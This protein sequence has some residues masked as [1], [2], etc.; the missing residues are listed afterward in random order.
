MKNKITSL[1]LV[2]ECFGWWPNILF[3]LVTIIFGPSIC[4]SAEI[5]Y[6]AGGIIE[7]LWLFLGGG[8]PVIQDKLKQKAQKEV[9][10]EWNRKKN[11]IIGKLSA[12]SRNRFCKFE[13]TGRNIS[14]IINQSR[15]D[16][17]NA[18]P[19]KLKTV[20]QLLWLSLKLL[21]SREIMVNNV[22]GNTKDMLITKIE[23][24]KKNRENEKDP[25]LI[26][27][28]D[29]TIKTMEQRLETFEKVSND[30]KSI[31]LNLL[32][33]EEQ[34]ELLKNLTAIEIQDNKGS[35]TKQIDNAQQSI[36]DT[37][38][39][40]ETAKDLFAPLDDDLTETPPDDIFVQGVSSGG[41]I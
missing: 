13:N 27:T 31:D 37:Q 35:L 32:R 30:M 26:E 15:K 36:D 29:S 7:A 40:M 20:N 38:E 33:I 19:S 9:L 11:R 17:I 2:K 21:Y 23:N 5:A 28:L 3:L 34:L 39:W 8:T 18:D 12:V 22:K 6:I 25:K 14:S 4:G 1:D 16:G 41:I 10:A 24:M